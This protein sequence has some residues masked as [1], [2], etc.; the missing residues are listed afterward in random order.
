MKKKLINSK[1]WELVPYNY[2]ELEWEVPNGTGPGPGRSQCILWSANTMNL[3]KIQNR[4]CRK[5][6]YEKSIT[7]Y[8]TDV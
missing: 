2:R 5:E 7:R 6:I 3:S 1:D 8:E 4:N